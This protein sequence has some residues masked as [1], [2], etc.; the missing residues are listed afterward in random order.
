MEVFS[1]GCFYGEQFNAAHMEKNV[2][3]AYAK[4]EQ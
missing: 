1:F 3:L 4:E 2:F